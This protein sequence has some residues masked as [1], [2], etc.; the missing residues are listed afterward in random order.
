MKKLE[1]LDF[2]IDAAGFGLAVTRSDAWIKERC[3]ANEGQLGVIVGRDFYEDAQGN[4]ICWPRVYWEGEG[5]ERGCHPVNIRPFRDS[6][7]LPSLVMWE[8]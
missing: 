3:G 1:I 4:L 6:V 8:D 7:Q 2:G 5:M